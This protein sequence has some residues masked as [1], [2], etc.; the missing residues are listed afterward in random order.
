MLSNYIKIALRIVRKD[1]TFSFI[2]VVGLA[3]GLAVALLIIQYVRFELSYEQS[4]PRA[5]Q[6][7]RLSIDYMN[8]GTVDAQDA[9]TFPPIGAK[10]KQEM[11]EVVNYTRVY[12]LQKPTT[13][14]Q[15]SDRYYVVDKVYAVDS[16]FFS[17]FN[18]PL[19]RGSRNGLFTRPARLC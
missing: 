6:I 5:N 9:E 1:A 4:N 11:N 2:N 15:I 18:Y 14:V 7:V 19:V 16:S 10:A 17:L 3:S 8:G 13:T 12:A